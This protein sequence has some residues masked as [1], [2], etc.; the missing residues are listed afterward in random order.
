[1]PISSG[2]FKFGQSVSVLLSFMQQSSNVHHVEKAMK[3]IRRLAQ[4]H[5]Q[6]R[7]WLGDCGAVQHAK[8]RLQDVTMTHGT[9]IEATRTL[10]ALIDTCDTC[11]E[12]FN[13]EQMV[14]GLINLLKSQQTKDSSM[15]NYLIL[16]SVSL[17]WTAIQRS[18]CCFEEML[19]HQGAATFC[20]FNLPGPLLLVSAPF[21]LR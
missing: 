11:L 19:E 16:Q 13:S 4:Q 14:K 3:V 2:C 5:F 17:L 10:H 15:P 7:S 18:D 9:H 20:S 6:L 8:A 21:V 12:M 1:V